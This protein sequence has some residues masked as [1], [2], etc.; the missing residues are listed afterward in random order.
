MKSH[1]KLISF[2]LPLLLL[3]ALSCSVKKPCVTLIGYSLTS[4]AIYIYNGTISHDKGLVNAVIK[5]VP[6]GK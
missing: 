2:F 6:S 4:S 1:S 5:T 3:L